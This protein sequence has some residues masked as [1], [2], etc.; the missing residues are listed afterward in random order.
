MI[1]P[2]STAQSLFPGLFWIREIFVRIEE[3][4]QVDWVRQQAHATLTGLHKGYE[5]GIRIV[6]FP[7]RVKRV[8][9]TVDIVKI[10]IYASLLVTF[11]LG[12]VG[13]T[14]IMLAAV[15][16][17]TREIGLRKALG[18]KEEMILLQFLTE[19]VLISL[20]AGSI[21]VASGLI[22]VQIL[23]GFLDLE[24]SARVMLMSVGLDLV[25]TLAIGVVSGMYPSLRASRLDPVTAM[26]FE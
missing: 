15:Q 11:I 5:K 17:R 14:N 22:S 25:F 26:R 24:A 1:I 21:G 9:T 6:Y 20:L 2:I 8:Q 3:W 4:N 7:E 23:R 18:A 10:F 19:S 16:D 12:K 13:L